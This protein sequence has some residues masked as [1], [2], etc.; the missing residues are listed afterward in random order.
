MNKLV[1]GPVLP[2]VII[3]VLLYTLYPVLI[4]F[5][6]GFSFGEYGLIEC[7]VEGALRLIAD[8]PLRADDV[9]DAGVGEDRSLV[10]RLAGSKQD[11]LRV[12]DIDLA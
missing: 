10:E 4:G 1:A 7:C 2:D 12:W 8:T 6:Y 5:A 3:T 11:A 9:L